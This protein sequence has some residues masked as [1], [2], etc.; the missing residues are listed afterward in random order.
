MLKFRSMVVGADRRGASS[1]SEDDPRITS[2]GRLL[3]RF[4]LD[5]LPQL[6]NVL[7][8]DMS[9]V[10]PRP[11]VQ[12]AVDLYSDEERALLSLRPG[13]TDF[14]SLRFRNEGEILKGSSDPDRD[15]LLKIAPAK[16]RLGLHYVRNCSL[17]TDLRIITATA[18]SVLG[19]DPGWCLPPDPGIVGVVAS[20]P[21][22]SGSAT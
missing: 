6:L 5:E 13:V 7:R 8:G 15:Y 20:P 4:K 22:E 18:L 9:F 17:W 3:R 16:I 19:V 14:A 2:V 12:W 11:Q 10:G 1:T 21:Q